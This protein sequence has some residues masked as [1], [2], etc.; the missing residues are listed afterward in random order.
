[1]RERLLSRAWDSYKRPILRAFL[2]VFRNRLSAEDLRFVDGLTVV[3][4]P[5]YRTLATVRVP[6]ESL[7]PIHEGQG[8]VAMSSTPHF[9]FVK[10][11]LGY[12]GGDWNKI[13]WKRY[14]TDG[15]SLGSFPGPGRQKRF[16]NLIED[17]R[18]SPVDVH[19]LVALNPRFRG[20]EIVDGFHRAAIV[21]V[22]HPGTR[23]S[24]SVVSHIVR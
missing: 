20:F 11:H 19:L 1:M 8:P 15:S 13:G 6:V 5:T 16:E 12:G 7:F 22:C 14:M 21:S 24:C 10:A 2:R 18:D 17:I 23:V 4:S 9:S 3:G